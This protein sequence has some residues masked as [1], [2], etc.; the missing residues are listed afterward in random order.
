MFHYLEYY[1]FIANDKL[2]FDEIYTDNLD[3]DLNQVKPISDVCTM[4]NTKIY[5]CVRLMKYQNQDK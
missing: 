2:T 1:I 5:M 3:K 4:R